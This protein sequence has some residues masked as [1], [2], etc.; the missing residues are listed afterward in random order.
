M[1]WV[2]VYD[3]R[4]NGLDFVLFAS[5][6][7]ATVLYDAIVLSYL[8]GGPET[9]I[10]IVAMFGTRRPIN[11]HHHIPHR[12]SLMNKCIMNR[13]RKKNESAKSNDEACST[14]VTALVYRLCSSFR[15]LPYNMTLK[16]THHAPWDD[17]PCRFSPQ[18]GGCTRYGTGAPLFFRGITVLTI[19]PSLSVSVSVSG[20]GCTSFFPRYH[21]PHYN[22][23]TITITIS[24]SI[25]ISITR[26]VILRVP[27]TLDGNVMKYWYSC[28]CVNV[29]YI[30][31]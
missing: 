12:R 8:I 27:A 9:A 29:P 14:T 17:L 16:T 3:F 20:S 13:G 21:S 15:L 6:V 2:R 28:Y 31:V 26:C 22:T 18:Q 5:G 25:R 11:V 23:I 24:I 10:F 30:S 4:V 1:R 7:F 19:T